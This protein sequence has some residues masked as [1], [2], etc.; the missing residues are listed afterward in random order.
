MSK[1]AEKLELHTDNGDDISMQD[2]PA[3]QPIEDTPTWGLGEYNYIDIWE[4]LLEREEVANKI[5]LILT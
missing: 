5:I 2:C 4:C 1:P 3:Y